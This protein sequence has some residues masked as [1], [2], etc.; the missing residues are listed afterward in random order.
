MYIDQH[1]PY[2]WKQPIRGGERVKLVSLTL[3]D[4]MIYNFAFSPDNTQLVIARGRPQ[5][6]ALLIDDMK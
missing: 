4:N 5:S 6:D 3:Q 2:I 1:Y